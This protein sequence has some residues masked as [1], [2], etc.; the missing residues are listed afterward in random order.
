MPLYKANHNPITQDPGQTK[1]IRPHNPM[2]V[3]VNK[4]LI[5]KMHFNYVIKFGIELTLRYY[6]PI[7]INAIRYH[8]KW[9]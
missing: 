7:K 5:K 2:I 4:H 6:K 8:H 1:D 3:I 9:L